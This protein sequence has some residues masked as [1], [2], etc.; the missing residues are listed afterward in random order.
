ML[1]IV[2]PRLTVILRW[3]SRGAESKHRLSL[4]TLAGIAYGC[5]VILTGL[6]RISVT[7]SSVTYPSARTLSAR[8]GFETAQCMSM[9]TCSGYICFEV[10]WFEVL[11]PTVM[12]V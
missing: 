1:P 11:L 4:S 3:F 6:Q 10:V 5:H 12:K 2:V 7:C 8:F 9:N